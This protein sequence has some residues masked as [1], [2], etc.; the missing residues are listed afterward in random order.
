MRES[1]EWAPV[2]YEEE[3]KLLKQYREA[4]RTRNKEE[5]QRCKKALLRLYVHHGEHFK[6][7]ESPDYT[8]AAYCLKKALELDENHPLANYRYAHL[9]FRDREYEKAAYHFRKALD[10]T[11][12]EGLNDSQAL[13]AQMMLVNCGLL[14]AKDALREVKFLQGNEFRTYDLDLIETY[15]EQMLIHSEEMLEQH[16]YCHVTPVG[17]RTISRG[18]FLAYPER[19][20]NDEVLLYVNDKYRIMYRNDW[21][22]LEY[23]AFCVF[24]VIV[25]ASDY[26]GTKDIASALGDSDAE[27]EL[28]DDHI[29]QLIFRL[30]RRLPYWDDIIETTKG[31]LRRRRKG[32]TYSLL[33]HSSVVLP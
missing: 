17:V 32:V 27:L 20:E 29:R 10:G 7:S 22:T 11:P 6:M 23:H 13:V 24:W 30:S 28:R 31:G 26:V 25:R 5:E 33:C 19:V 12:E 14:I 4:K 2:P 9:I 3:R 18:D 21:R 8:S 16:I 15:S 1:N